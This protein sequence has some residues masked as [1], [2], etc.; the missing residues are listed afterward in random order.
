MVDELTLAVETDRHRS[1]AGRRAHADD[2]AVVQLVAGYQ[3]L[4]G[5]A[6]WCRRA[7]FDPPW[8]GERLPTSR[9]PVPAAARAPRLIVDELDNRR[10]L[11]RHSRGCPRRNF[12][13]AA[14]RPVERAVL[15][16]A[17]LDLD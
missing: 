9:H 14:A 12:R 17:E 15:E 8:P 3:E 1:S 16:Q 13:L 2:A 6:A 5:F 10:R 4:A 11:P 7:A